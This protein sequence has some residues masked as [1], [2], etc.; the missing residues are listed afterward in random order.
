VWLARITVGL[1]AVVLLF[2]QFRPRTAHAEN[3]NTAT[4]AGQVVYR[5]KPSETDPAIHRFDEAHYVV[6]TQ[7]TPPRGQLVIFMPGTGGRP[8]AAVRLLSVVADQGYR[9]IGLE[10]NDTPAVAEI[11]P[12][13]PAPQCATDFR[14]ERIFGGNVSNAVYNSDAESITNRLAKLL[15]YLDRQHPGDEWREYLRDGA[16]N[17]SRIVVSGLSQGAGM[18]AYIAKHEPVA[19]VV[20]FSGPWD[21]SG[22][23]GTLAPWLAKP[24]ATPTERWFAEYHRLE[25]TAGLLA[26]AYGALQI[27]AS[28][29]LVFDLDLG[30]NPGYSRANN[31][32]H[33]STIRLPG[34]EPSWRLL[35]GRSADDIIR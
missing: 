5:V 12:P 2:A 27:P 9:A 25:K 13:S 7:E 30:E 1:L 3:M 33:A 26:R 32:Y 35:F 6:F 16:P 22:I 14:R 18:A 15:E 21:Y 4:R 31:P 34:Y 10:Y 20:L 8:A 28:H 29:I 23:S 19:R 11:C 24:S 17:W